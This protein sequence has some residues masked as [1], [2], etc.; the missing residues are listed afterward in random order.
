[1][2]SFTLTAYSTVAQTLVGS[3]TGILTDP[4][5][6]LVVN[7]DAVS[8]TAGTN[9][10]YVNGSIISHTNGVGNAVDHTGVDLHAFVGP[11]GTVTSLEDDAFDIRGTGAFSLVN[12]GTI[13]AQETAVKSRVADG[14]GINRLVNSGK[15]LGRDVAVDFDG[16]GSS[17][18]IMNSGT[19]EGGL[20][21]ILSNWLYI[22]STGATLLNNSGI[23]SGSSAA[24]YSNDGVGNDTIFNSGIMDGNILTGAG[25]D[26]YEGPGVLRGEFLAGDGNDTAAGGDA[27]D[28]FRGG[29][30]ND[31]LVG[32]GGDDSLFGDNGLDTLLGGDGNDRI[33]GG[34]DND[35]LNGNAGDDTLVG[36]SGNDVLVGQDGS[37]VLDGGA[38]NDTMDG[39]AGDDQLEGGD[40][41]DILRGRAGEDDLAGGL[42][43]D[44]LTGGA[45]ADSFVFRSLAEAGLGA[46]RDQILDF[47]Q[48]SDI[49]IV[50]GLHP[51]VFEFRG[52]AG[53]APSGN[54]ELRLF[55][56]ATGSTI[57]QMDANG[58][59]ITDAEIRVANV[60]GLTATDFVL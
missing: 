60:T 38:D 4:D 1:M 32:R 55:E 34:A 24:Y 14:F 50:A 51:G 22:S 2:A 45:G 28:V 39:G 53:Y 11:T 5:A 18:Y 12:D 42:G 46:T 41:N 37:D 8:S 6:N 26:R 56:T 49:I 17:Q 31:L 19:I 57:V 48:G 9:Y 25:V 29:N 27:T 15:I 10:L 13:M 59:G 52:T 20:F 58:D 16:G 43:M 23:I 40:G 30:D 54:P 33:E 47:E 21:G 3:E 36:G 35:T 44:L 7:G